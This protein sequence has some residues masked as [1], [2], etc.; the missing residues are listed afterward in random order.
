MPWNQFF[1]F[2]PTLF[3]S[4]RTIMDSK[5][6]AAVKEEAFSPEIQESG[7]TSVES[8]VFDAK[9]TRKLIRKIDWH[10]IPFLSLIYL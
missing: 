8:L 2:L 9:A 6:T 5:T 7:S 4:K 1:H 10:L 3:A